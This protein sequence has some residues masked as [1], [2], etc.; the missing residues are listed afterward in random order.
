MGRIK[1]AAAAAAEAACRPSAF[2]F[3]G[4][5]RARA[6]L[7]GS[8]K[9]ALT[10]EKQMVVRACSRSRARVCVFVFILCTHEYVSMSAHGRVSEY[11]G[12]AWTP[13]VMVFKMC[14]V[15]LRYFLSVSVWLAGRWEFLLFVYVDD[16]DYY[17]GFLLAVVSRACAENYI[18]NFVRPYA[19]SVHVAERDTWG[20]G[21]GFSSP[22]GDWI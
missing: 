3:V 6:V 19:A 5:G 1:C 7:L 2:A 12:H 22:I 4:I 14:G 20:G 10:T 11:A 13:A 8:R 18:N 15:F 16:V 17:S 21:G 9:I